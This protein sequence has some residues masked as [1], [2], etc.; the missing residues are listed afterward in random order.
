MITRAMRISSNKG[1]SASNKE[2]GSAINPGG[3]V[4]VPSVPVPSQ[5][6]RGIGPIAGGR[7]LPDPTQAGTKGCDWIRHLGQAGV[8]G[9]FMSQR[10]D[11]FISYHHADSPGVDALVE[12]LR[13]E[14]LK[15]WLDRYEVEGASAIQA[16]IDRGLSRSKGLLAW[17]SMDYPQSRVCQ[18]ELTA[19]LIAAQAETAAVRRLLVVNPEA[20]LAPFQPQQLRDLRYFGFDGDYTGLA[21][22][23]A[24]AIRP[25]EG[26]LGDLCRQG[27]PRWYGNYH[28]LGSDRFVGRDADLWEIHTTL[29]ANP[30]SLRSTRGLVQV[31]GGSGSGKTLLAEEYALRFGSSWPG[32]I[33][34]LNG[35][36]SGVDP[37]ESVEDQRTRRRI[38][39]SSQLA[40]I[41]GQLGLKVRAK[42]DQELRADIG[43]LLTE[44]Y[45]WIVDDLPACDRLELERWMAPSGHGQTL[46]TTRAQMLNCIGKAIDLSELTP[47][48]ARAL[49]TYGHPPLLDE[50]GDIDR[51][52]EYLDGHAL[53]LDV[54]RTAC[55]R[56]GY[57]SFRQS[58]D[59]PGVEALGLAAQL[60][61]DLANGYNLYIAATLLIS[62]QALDEQGKDGLRLAAQ[63]EETPVPVDLLTASLAEADGLDPQE[64][65]IRAVLGLQQILCQSLAVETSGATA[66]RVLFLVDR[67]LRYQ[68]I[69]PQRGNALQEAVMN[70]LAERMR[71]AEDIGKHGSLSLSLPHVQL[72][73]E[74]T[75]S[76]AS[77]NLAG[78]LGWYE[79]EPGRYQAAQFWWEL[80]YRGCRSLLGEDHPATLN[81]MNNLAETLR[82][83]GDL[84]G[85]RSLQEQVL[86]TR[87]RVLGPDHA[88]T[89]TSMNNFSET[90]RNQGDLA[91][92][93]A[94]Q[95]QVL[96][97]SRRVLGPD[98]PH[99]LT[100]MGN[101]AGT[102][103]NQGDLAGARVLEEQV[104]E[105]R[106]RVL[107]EEHPDTS[108]SAWNLFRTLDQLGESDQ[109]QALLRDYLAWLVRRD[110][111]GLGAPQ[112]QIREAVLAIIA[113]PTPPPPAA[114][115]PSS[116][117]DFHRDILSTR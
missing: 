74:K 51:I 4:R 39:Y 89:L 59:R 38:A 23:I 30:S 36:G 47:P 61:G 3:P 17:Y 2:F 105:S 66:Y 27:K 45:L 37:D 110:P 76:S 98:H 56:R 33:F 111:T 86:A 73:A 78:W 21:R 72:L 49:L 35:L 53:A 20:S 75:C 48:E 106:S 1:W 67:T 63:L 100:S 26:V 90:L 29:A 115:L 95:E 114:H 82:S 13:A 15:V 101:L 94:L 70:V 11:L 77:L 60:A 34:W 43:R 58:L 104:L 46:V 12:A 57:R 93:C 64:A 18:W 97:A 7:Y 103:W 85:A 81:S 54:A 44:P 42:N 107:G 112:R 10:Y 96:A 116:V 16:G 19:G 80:E 87:R 25:I 22:E 6:G 28:G 5:A 109:A 62:I 50:A 69:D 52:L 71:D 31:R 55:R 40:E 88:S 84:A 99:T 92:A 79:W 14:G 117:E 68:E 9:D 32:G 41:A 8:R 65:E 24:E 102:L 91:G 113:N 108:I 83:Q